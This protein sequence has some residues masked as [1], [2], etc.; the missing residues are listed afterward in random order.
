MSNDLPPQAIPTSKKDEN[1]EKACMDSLERIGLSQFSENLKFIDYYRMTEGKVSFTE[2]SELIPQLR[3]VESLLDDYQ[4]PTT[5]KHYDLLGIILNYLENIIMTGKDTFF[6]VD[7]SDEATN[8]RIRKQTELLHQYISEEWEKQLQI[9]LIE[10]GIDPDQ[11]EFES[12]EEKQAYIQEIENRR[13]ALTPPEIAKY[14]STDWKAAA[15]DWAEKTIESDTRTKRLNEINRQNVRDYL[16]TGRCF[17]HYYIAYDEYKVEAWSPKN[18]F[19]SQTIDTKYP[20]NGEYIGRIHFYTP[21]DFINKKGYMLTQKEQETILNNGKEEV[22]RYANGNGNFDSAMQSNFQENHFVPHSNYYDYQLISAIEAETG[23]PMTNKSILKTDGT[24]E[25]FVGFMPNRMGTVNTN[26]N[27]YARHL[28]DDLNLRTDMICVTEA[29]WRSYQKTGY[30]TYITETGSKESEFVTD[31]VLG[32]FLKDNG[33]KE[34]K[35]VSLEDAIKERKPNT[36]VWQ[37]V[38][39]IWKGEKAN[40]TATDLQKDI[41]Y[42]IEPLPYQIKGGGDLFDLQLPVS[43]LVDNNPSD[44]IMPFQNGYNIVM[45]QKM[46]LLEKEIG[47]FFLFDAQYIP[48]DIKEHGDTETAFLNMI[49]IAKTTGLFGVDGSAKNLQGQS[50][51]N[52]FAVQDMS[53]GAMIAQKD[54]Q[55]QVFKMMAYEQFGITPQVLGEPVKYQTATGVNQMMSSTRHQTDYLYEAFSEFESRS[56]EIHLAVAQY[57]QGTGKDISLEYTKSDLTKAWLKF[58]DPKFPLRRFG[59]MFISDSKKR[60]E[61]EA[62]KQYMLSQNTMDMDSLELI[63]I[64]GGESMV[65]LSNIAKIERKRKEINQEKQRLHELQ[66][67]ENQYKQQGEQ[68]LR[69]WVLQEIT[70]QRDRINKLYEEQINAFGKAADKDANAES[71]DMIAKATDLSIKATKIEKDFAIKE[72]QLDLIEQEQKDKYKQGSAKLAMDIEKLRLEKE[73]M[74]NQKYIAEINKN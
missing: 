44:K 39:Q 2:L 25:S 12:E 62:V 61:V 22:G 7:V 37:Y 71:N 64:I 45:N 35:D 73:K 4:I 60:Q 21:S 57:A 30:L 36:I 9:K 16:R 5:I 41:Y 20:Q 32:D 28:R 18:T 33:I 27:R 19:F 38:P 67:Q 17:K 31:E 54:A 24:T 56:L 53:M 29:Y 69:T 43:G 10:S 34:L 52:Q 51:F 50:A 68:E 63:N 14:L 70:N 8:D 47:V 74:D 59:I 58:S 66:L 6:P 55:A 11:K 1:W 46:N 40:T 48:S 49:N 3:E 72:R 23:I 15:V 42:G 65:A 26:I 13:Q